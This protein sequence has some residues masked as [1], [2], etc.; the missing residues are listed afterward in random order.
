MQVLST[1]KRGA[2]ISFI[3]IACVWYKPMLGMHRAKLA[4]VIG[5]QRAVVW[6]MLMVAPS[7][8]ITEAT[9]ERPL[10]VKVG[11]GPSKATFQEKSPTG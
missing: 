4:L 8:F 10:A 6:V 7:N 3:A 9:D 5:M 11:P 2:S 1:N